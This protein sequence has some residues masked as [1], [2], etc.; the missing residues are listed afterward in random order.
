MTTMQ[1]Q[2]ST[3]SLF[4]KHRSTDRTHIKGVLRLALATVMCSSAALT[5]PIVAIAAPG[6][7]FDIA[8]S[9]ECRDVT[10]RE[11]ALQYP[12]QRLIEVALS[13]STRFNE[14]SRND[15]D[16]IDIE[17][18]G[19]TAGLLVHDFA[20]VTQL[21]SDIT[22]EIETTKTTKHA[23][24]LEGT[25]GGTL[26]IPGAEAA[27]HL[28]PSISGGLSGC[29]T[30]TEKINRLPPKDVVVVSG[31]CDEGRGVFFKLKRT[32]QTSLEGVHELAVTFVAPRSWPRPAIQVKCDALGQR[33]MLWMKQ[34]ATLGEADRYVQLIPAPSLPV[35]QVVLKPTVD[36]TIL[37]TGLPGDESAASPT[38][39]R[40][41][42]TAPLPP[43][44]ADK[45]AAEPPKKKLAVETSLSVK[46]A[47]AEMAAEVV[48]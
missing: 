10:P 19:T 20:P 27:A 38:K 44:V 3:A 43:K 5:T 29:E 23:R 9:V 16:E 47:K 37:P 33:K 1:S 8:R 14:V 36:A 26:P 48:E 7:E 4:G 21:A 18:S 30:A 11:R 40:P 41:G 24:S 13:V 22:R 35:R 42:R 46:S 39:W 32:T 45:S 15:V 34:S 25:L 12:G 6:V 28:T 2:L 31:T 17:V